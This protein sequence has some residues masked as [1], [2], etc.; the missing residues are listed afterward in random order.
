MTTALRP[1]GDG[2]ALEKQLPFDE[3]GDVANSRAGEPAP[4]PS[5][6]DFDGVPAADWDLGRLGRRADFEGEQI[7]A[8][9]IDSAPHYWIIRIEH[10]VKA[11]DDRAGLLPLI[12]AVEHGLAS[13]RRA[14]EPG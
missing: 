2:V 4:R 7:T 13:L 12:Q 6:N 5:A 9:E 10:E 3:Q 14:W 8:C 1:S 11:P